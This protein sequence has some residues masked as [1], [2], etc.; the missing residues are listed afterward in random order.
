M[1]EKEKK[2]NYS[3]DKKID[4]EIVLQLIKEGVEIAKY[5]IRTKPY[6]FQY[7]RERVKIG[8]DE[9]WLVWDWIVCNELTF[10]KADTGEKISL[11]T[12][13]KDTEIE[14]RFNELVRRYGID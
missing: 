1:E 10:E 4:I 11:G 8:N 7:K 13:F 3:M 5:L 12:S 6:G 9:G 14:E 2:A